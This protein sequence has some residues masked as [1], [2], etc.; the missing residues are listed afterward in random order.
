MTFVIV[1]I[2]TVAVFVDLLVHINADKNFVT[3]IT[4]V[5]YVNLPLTPSYLIV[6][7]HSVR[8]EGV[9]VALSL[10]LNGCGVLQSV[11][12][13]KLNIIK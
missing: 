5:R 6:V 12:R 1:I 4:D 9:V 8:C 7:N 3:V 13:F 2:V 11:M 10:P